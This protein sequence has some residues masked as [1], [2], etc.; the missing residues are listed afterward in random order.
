MR[1]ANPSHALALVT[2]D[3]LARGGVT[4]AVLAPGSRS[5]ALAL[6]LHADER[7]RLHVEID[8][9][10]A[11][12][13]ALGLGRA[14][15]RPAVVVTTS[16]SAVANLH[17]GVVEADADRVPLVVLS[18]DRPPELRHT[19]A[20]QT[21]DQL[22]IFGGAVRWFVEVGAPGDREGE[23]A[24]WRATACRL[25][26]E[27]TGLSGPPGPVHANLAFREPTVPLADDGRAPVATF[28]HALDGRAGRRPWTAL[29]RAPRVLPPEALEDLAQ[30]LGRV[31]RGLLLLGA[32]AAQGDAALALARALGWPVV[33]EPTSGARRGPD[34]VSTV[35]HLLAHEGFARTHVP[36]LVVRVGRG[37]LSPSVSRL[38]VPEVEQLVLD[39]WG[40]WDDPERAVA[41]RL[42]A[43]VGDTCRRLVTALG[44]VAG[45]PGARGAAAWREEWRRAEAAA[46]RALDGELDAQREPTE[47]R[48]ARDVAA[49]VPRGGTLVAASSMPVRDLER[50][51]A[52][53]EDLR[54]LGNRGA[55]GIDGLVSTALGAALAGPGPV[56]ALAGDLSL[57]HD[58]NGFLLAPDAARLDATFVVVDNDG[59]GIFHF[60][61]QAGFP[62]GFE[63]VFGTPHGREVADLAR[64][65]G[66]G[67]RRV[68]RADEL[69]GAVSEALAAGGIRLVHVR[70]DRHANVGWQRRLTAAVHRALDDLGPW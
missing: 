3:E 8:E 55:S 64:L 6:A 22:K 59:G 60:L 35:H 13:L 11:A 66:L 16:G 46:R 58:A 61:P 54:V 52:P 25:L 38:L 33:A 30:R 50:Y 49:A 65:H 28:S 44:G 69:A 7:V 47:P 67:Y 31:P 2:V 37:A 9:R 10:S 19:G 62:E 40:T 68:E 14:S 41:Q 23:V 32:G 42:I 15:G 70:T 20:N 43:D 63:R 36:D 1:A 29:Q 4:D 26:A 21:I 18:A 53:R 48:T 57:L 12:F 51:A 24:Y 34:V 45:D 56:V 5:T 39:P 27:A 17:P